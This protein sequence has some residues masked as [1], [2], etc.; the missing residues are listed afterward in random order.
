MSVVHNHSQEAQNDSA[1]QSRFA[2]SGRESI[3]IRISAVFNM[4]YNSSHLIP[5]FY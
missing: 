1:E 5:I 2:T 4:S 3:G